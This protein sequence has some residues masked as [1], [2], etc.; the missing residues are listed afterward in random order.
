VTIAALG[1]QGGGRLTLTAE[2]GVIIAP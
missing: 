2:A 1:W